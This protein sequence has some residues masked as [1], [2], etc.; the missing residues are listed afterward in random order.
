MKK[1]GV[2]RTSLLFVIF[3]FAIWI[4]ITMI[5]IRSATLHDKFL[6]SSEE[7]LRCTFR[8]FDKNHPQAWRETCGVLPAFGQI[9]MAEYSW[10]Q[11]TIC[12]QSLFIA[13]CYI[14][15]IYAAFYEYIRPESSNDVY[16]QPKGLGGRLNAVARISSPLMLWFADKRYFC[17]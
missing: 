10:L 3:Y 16:M 9:N 6:V 15:A 8:H 2:I 17:C 13:S 1:I 11:L 14:F 4:S 5:V 12:G 7:W